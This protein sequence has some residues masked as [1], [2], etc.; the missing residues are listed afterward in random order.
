MNL[1]GEADRA[2]LFEKEILPLLAMK[3]DISRPNEKVT[4]HTYIIR[5]TKVG[6]VTLYAKSG[7]IQ[8][9][10]GWITDENFEWIKK[11]L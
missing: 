5:D 8:T 3:Y 2:E 11:N 1:F 7:R 4:R 9:A 10:T 6:R